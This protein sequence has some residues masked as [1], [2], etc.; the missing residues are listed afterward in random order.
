LAAYNCGE[1]RV[2]RA[3]SRQH[4]NYLDNF[5]DLYHQLPTETSNYVPRF[6]ATLQIIKDPE[7]YGID[8]NLEQENPISFDT[9]K[10]EKSVRL[11]DVAKGL[12]A[13]EKTLNLLNSELRYKTTPNRYELKIPAGMGEKFA[14]VI[15]K[16]SKA[17]RPGGAKYIRYRVKKGDTLSVLSR[18]YKSSVNA[19][20]AAN[21]LTSKHSIRAGK[22]LKIPSRG[23]VYSKR[24]RKPALK[25][26]GVAAYRVKKG[27]S[28]WLIARRFGTTI[29]EIKRLNGL[30]RN[31]LTIGQV[32]K[33]RSSS[34]GDNAVSAKTCVVKKGDT[35]SLIALKRG[36][37][38]N[39]LLKLNN[40]NKNTLIHP[41]QLVIVR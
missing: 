3:I 27:D 25:E 24:L 6:L 8:L 36:I 20:M 34:A 26:G 19:I 30:R 1:G 2:L 31:N 40:L 7:K 17:K 37:S 29:S 13:S 33:I 11:R 12:H 22:W 4:V 35:L 15:D 41:G 5:W 21:H 9:V 10:T 23:Y 39:R 16:V 38:L 18:R 32:I 14:S 28:L